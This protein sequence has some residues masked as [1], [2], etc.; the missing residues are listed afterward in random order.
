VNFT[1]EQHE[2]YQKPFPP[3]VADPD[4]LQFLQELHRFFRSGVA[5][6]RGSSLVPGVATEVLQFLQLLQG[7]SVSLNISIFV[8][9]FFF[10]YCFCFFCY[11]L[12]NVKIFQ[13]R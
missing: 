8:F 10:F 2:A 9:F 1:H 12:N 7:S 6:C 13:K 11:S 4:V 5:S 3:G